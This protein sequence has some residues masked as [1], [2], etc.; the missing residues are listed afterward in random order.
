[1][2]DGIAASATH[3]DDLDHR[4]L[5]FSFKHFKRHNAS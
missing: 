1:M 4:A 3:T 5:G 2:L